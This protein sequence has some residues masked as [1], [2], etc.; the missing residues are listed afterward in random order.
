MIILN[1]NKKV[2]LLN[3]NL[4][5]QQI[6]TVFGGYQLIESDRYNHN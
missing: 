5:E 6:R 3:C 2:H 4:P 1:A